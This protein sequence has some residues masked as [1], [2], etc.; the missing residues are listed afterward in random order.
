MLH[1]RM[2]G[3]L[4]LWRGAGL[5]LAHFA[6]A[7]LLLMMLTSITVKALPASDVLF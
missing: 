2:H 6:R 3:M 5:G 7:H 4:E 1:H